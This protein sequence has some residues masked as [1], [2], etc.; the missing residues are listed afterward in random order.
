MKF[1][2]TVLTVVVVVVTCYA[3]LCLLL[4][5]FQRSLLY[6]PQPRSV[7][8]PGSK[9]TLKADDADLVVSV[10][11]RS[12][13]KALVYFGG[14]AED[15]SLSLAT[16][17]QAFPDHAIFMLHYRG[18]GGSSG[19]PTEEANHRDAALLLAKV[20]SSFS[21]V[22]V[23]GRSLGSGVALRLAARA[24]VERVVLVTPYDSIANLAAA[25]YP[26][27][28]ARHLLLDRYDSVKDAPG[29]RTPTTIVVAEYD[30]VI[31]RSSTENLA[32]HFAPGVARVVVVRGTGHNTIQGS[33]DYFEAISSAQ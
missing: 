29:V 4:F 19:R 31:P 30:E 24:Q 18:Y 32:R 17:G 20:R 1:R 28:P 23:I 7:S 33:T 3:L 11:A 8:T 26:F 14:N 16:F 5:I 25:A 12:G 9:I 2:R 6:F 27:V 13:S 21:H 15:V 22:T 10:V